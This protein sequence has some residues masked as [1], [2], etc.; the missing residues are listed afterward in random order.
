M[1]GNYPTEEELA[2]ICAWPWNDVEGLRLYVFGL[3]NWPE[4]GASVEGGMWRLATGGWSGNEDIIAALQ[5]NHM[6]WALCWQ[7]SER[8]GLHWFKPYP[9]GEDR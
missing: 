4:F 9:Q 3:W 2:R 5:D 8:G 1:S 7:R 6:F